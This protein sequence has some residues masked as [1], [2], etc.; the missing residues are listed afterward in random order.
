MFKPIS[1]LLRRLGFVI[2]RET[3]WTTAKADAFASEKQIKTLQARFA[4]AETLVAAIERDRDS[5]QNRLLDVLKG[6]EATDP[7]GELLRL[8]EEAARLKRRCADLEEFRS[9][10]GERSDASL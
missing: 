1:Y 3:A 9:R 2:L 5:L 4:R 10:T 6:L 7:S 8:R